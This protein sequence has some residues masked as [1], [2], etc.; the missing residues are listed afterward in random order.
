MAPTVAARVMF[1][2]PKGEM[3]M[4]ELEL[5]TE[6]GRVPAAEPAAERAF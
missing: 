3:N 2:S 4:R 5:V 1:L 6:A